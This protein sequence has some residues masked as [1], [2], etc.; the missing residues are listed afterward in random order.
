VLDNIPLD[1][2]VVEDLFCKQAIR[3][4]T[5]SVDAAITHRSVL[6]RFAKYLQT[7]FNNTT[8]LS[9]AARP[10]E[11]NRLDCGHSLC[12]S[13]IVIHGQT[14]LGEPW[15]FALDQCPL[16]EAPNKIN[17]SLKPYNA[18]IR[19]LGISGRPGDAFAVN[20]LK[21]LEARLQLPKLPIRELFDIAFGT[22]SGLYCLK[23]E[24]CLLMFYRCSSYSRPFLQRTLD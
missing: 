1:K 21:E 18:G 13:C 15:N 22:G 14:V 23:F 24:T 16:C 4:V 6:S 8:C 19:A 12:D 7:I 20:F 3:N 5:E 17:V 9:C 11:D 10:P 2:A